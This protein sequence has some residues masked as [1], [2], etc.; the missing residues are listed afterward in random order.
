[1]QILVDTHGYKA[2]CRVCD[3]VTPYY[4]QAAGA[5]EHVAEHEVME[6]GN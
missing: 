6:H 1:M 4:T 2:R 5:R 3:Y